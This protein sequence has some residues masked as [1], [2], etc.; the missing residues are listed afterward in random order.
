[1]VVQPPAVNERIAVIS[2]VHGNLTALETVLAHI[3]QSGITRIFNLGDLVGKGPRSA[4]VVDRCRDVCEVIVQGNWDASVSE[5]PD[6]RHPVRQWH[7]AQLGEERLAYLAGLPGSF[8]FTLSGR[9]ARVFHASERGVHDRV[10]ATGTRQE[11]RAMFGNTPFTGLGG[12]PQIVGYGDIHAAYVLNFENRT[13]FNAGSVGNPL[14]M[15]L[16]CYAVLEGI[17]GAEAAYPWS[18]CFVRLPYDI[19]AEVAAAAASGMPDLDHYANELRRAVY[20]GLTPA[21]TI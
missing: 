19:E 5:G 8:D 16:A 3:R 18:L 20:R 4:A 7:R 12:E 13:L 15:P 17:Y 21:P 14:D 6:P 11:H 10:H 9:R 2:D 1:M